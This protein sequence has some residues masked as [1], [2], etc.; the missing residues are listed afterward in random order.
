MATLLSE[1]FPGLSELEP[2]EAEF[3]GQLLKDV[4]A[5]AVRDGTATLRFQEYDLR[6]W[7]EPLGALLVA[8][9]WRLTRHGAPLARDT[10]IQYAVRK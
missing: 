10:A 3:L 1:A 5:A 9:T 7:R 8:V 4:V 2:R 6:A